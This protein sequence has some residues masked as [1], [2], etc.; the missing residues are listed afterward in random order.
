MTRYK[1]EFLTNS[2]CC[3]V[4]ALLPFPTES[5]A[6]EGVTTAIKQMSENSF[7]SLVIR[8]AK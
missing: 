1:S 7:N 6:N 8:G 5:W 3:G 2:N 4:N